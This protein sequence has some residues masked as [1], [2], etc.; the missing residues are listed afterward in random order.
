MGS[1][2]SRDE[3]VKRPTTN[4]GLVRRPTHHV[5]FLQMVLVVASRSTC[6]RRSVG[7]VLV[8]SGNHILAAGYNGVTRGFPHCLDTPCPGAGLP[9]GTGIDK[10]E[11]IHAEQNALLQCKS[12]DKIATCY[13]STFPCIACTKLLL[14][15]PCQQVVYLSE[16]A[17]G[18]QE[19][20]LRAGRLIKQYTMDQIYATPAI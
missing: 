16:Y 17:A 12:I 4:L 18:G 11:A 14:N 7:C 5:Y 13:T 1:S 9:S 19:L 20:W 8:D 3:S 2:E 6:R 10:C 15:T